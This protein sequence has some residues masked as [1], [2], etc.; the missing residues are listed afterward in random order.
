[1]KTLLLKIESCSECP[2]LDPYLNIQSGESE[3]KCGL[4]GSTVKNCNSINSDCPL[5][6]FK[7]VIK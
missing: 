6:D 1:M 2:R 4:T 3:Y 7:E 5:E